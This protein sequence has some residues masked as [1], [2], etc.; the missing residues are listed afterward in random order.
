MSQAWWLT[1]R[2]MA[3]RGPMVSGFV[4]RSSP[5]SRFL[6]NVS[7]AG[8]APAGGY[9]GRAGS[10]PHRPGGNNRRSK[11]SVDR[12]DPRQVAAQLCALDRSDLEQFILKGTRHSVR[13]WNAIISAVGDADWERGR[14]ILRLCSLGGRQRREKESADTSGGA[15]PAL[16]TMHYNALITAAGKHTSTAGRALAIFEDLRQAGLQPTSVTHMVLLS[17]T[18]RSGSWNSTKKALDLCTSWRAASRNSKQ[19]QDSR[20]TELYNAQLQ[21]CSRFG[22]WH[23]AQAIWGDMR[24]L[25]VPCDRITYATLLRTA[26]AARMNADV[27]QGIWDA[28]HASTLLP[29]ASLYDA[30]L[31]A[32]VPSRD[33]AA[34]C[35]IWREMAAH[36]LTRR[37]SSF[38]AVALVRACDSIEDL[39][40]VEEL[41]LEREVP[42]SSEEVV[43]RLVVYGEL[44]E[45]GDRNQLPNSWRLLEDAK[46]EGLADVQVYNTLIALCGKDNALEHAFKA[47]EEL[48]T[49]AGL[50]ATEATYRA[51]LSACQ[52]CGDTD[53]ALS[54]FRSMV[55]AGH[56]ASLP[57]YHDVMSACA[58][59]R[60]CELAQNLFEELQVAGLTPNIVSYN[61]LMDAYLKHSDAAATYQEV[62]QLLEHPWRLFALLRAQGL[63]PDTVT[64]GTLLA[65]CGRSGDWE[66]ALALADEMRGAGL[67]LEKERDLSNALIDA[68][69][70]HNSEA[71]LGVFR[72]AL[73]RCYARVFAVEVEDGA[74]SWQLDLRRLSPC[75]AQAAVIWW[76]QEHLA[77]KAA[78]RPDSMVIITG[79][80]KSR[81]FK[82]WQSANRSVQESVFELLKG[83]DAPIIEGGGGSMAPLG[84]AG[85]R[86]AHAPGG[87]GR[88]LL[89]AR[90]DDILD[91]RYEERG[92]SF[93]Q[94]C[95]MVLDEDIIPDVQSVVDLSGLYENMR[96]MWR[97]RAGRDSSC[98]L[99]QVLC[100]L[101]KEQVGR[102][103]PD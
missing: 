32:C 49:T 27:T 6:A 67:S 39:R 19:E 41:L 4:L 18:V 81:E 35:R 56:R 42:R 99:Q 13:T 15:L 103:L 97:R 17:A 25:E 29:D 89:D 60:D 20:R 93:N 86:D 83:M 82:T 91:V 63:A 38:A 52:R 47:Y 5:T 57:A 85:V 101:L 44:A 78:R 37:A 66:R 69:W 92:Q 70:D 54:V 21:A 88:L 74:L 16:N 26:T 62:R 1:R 71:A 24:D 61:I 43:A 58:K 10:R 40:R 31:Q 7:P 102:G 68:V 75:A 51:L 11:G 36:G 9:H 30:M 77:H 98:V 28:V 53:R 12:V 34:S 23:E 22:S 76:I 84:Q 64:Y 33:H 50:V 65:V 46:R 80:G 87:R 14:D 8:A 90:Y 3:G 79:W 73:E 96:M 2:W 95:D 72:R 94:W 55:S 48:A 59:T 45:K 100:L